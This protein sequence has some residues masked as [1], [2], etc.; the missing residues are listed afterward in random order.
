LTHPR[1]LVVDDQ[2]GTAY[3]LAT[4]ASSCNCE[5]R[6][7]TGGAEAVEIAAQWHPE[8][9]LLDLLMP[10][11][12]GFQVAERLPE[13]TKIVAVTALPQ[14]DKRVQELEFDRY[15]VKPVLTETV[16]HIIRQLTA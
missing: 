15:L 12:D 10:G 6:I 1:V 16:G 5:V 7:A 13:G 11:M 2:P 9:V 3:L 4:M 14:D 8:V